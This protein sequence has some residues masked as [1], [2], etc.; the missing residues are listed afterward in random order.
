MKHSK[1]KVNLGP[2]N[3]PECVSEHLGYQIF[4]GEA[5]R[6][7]PAGGGIPFYILPRAR[8]SRA[9]R[10]ATPRGMPIILVI[11]CATPTSLLP[12][13]TSFLFETT[14]ITKYVHSCLEIV[15]P[16]PTSTNMPTI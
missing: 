1:G 6:T 10:A 3:S 9:R 16:I 15:I 2:Q 13:P 14:D 12:T 5:T 7:P 8:Q 4:P 11:T